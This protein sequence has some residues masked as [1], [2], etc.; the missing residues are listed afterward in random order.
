MCVWLN[1]LIQ[2]T[3]HEILHFYNPENNTF[4]INYNRHV[5]SSLPRDNYG[6]NYNPPHTDY[7]Q[8]IT[9]TTTSHPILRN[10]TDALGNLLVGAAAGVSGSEA[11]HREKRGL[12]GP[13]SM[14]ECRR[15]DI[16]GSLVQNASPFLFPCTIEY[17]LICAAI[18]YVMWKSM[19]KR[20]AAMHRSRHG[21]YSHPNS[22]NVSYISN[23]Y[24]PM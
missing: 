11:H 18:L 24:Q 10:I 13:H 20:R 4:R 6:G 22:P 1:V 7:G 3:R 17:S 5:P 21:H 9:T 15:T 2:E 12:R 14:Y 19:A 8:P 16:M 23:S